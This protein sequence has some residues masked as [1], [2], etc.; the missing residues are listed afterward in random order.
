MVIWAYQSKPAQ[1]HHRM[2]FIF[3]VYGNSL[4]GPCRKNQPLFLTFTSSKPTPGFNV[5]PEY[6]AQY[7]TGG[8][9]TDLEAPP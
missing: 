2:G 8:Y 3:K 5:P 9:P 7:L 4:N 1:E 6:E